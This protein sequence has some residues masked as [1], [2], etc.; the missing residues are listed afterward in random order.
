MKKIVDYLPLFSVCLIYF[1]F[2]NLHGYY[3]EF[4]I[5]IYLYITAS[6]II[7]AFF[8]T[9]VFIA[10]VM[11]TSLIQGFVG[12]P[13]YVKEVV[14]K[15]QSSPPSRLKIF[16]SSILESILTWIVIM[17]AVQ[18]IIKWIMTKYFGYEAFDFQIFNLIASIF[19]LLGILWYLAH[20]GQQ[21][22]IRKSPTIA[23]IVIVCYMGL[24]I[25][26]YRKLD[27]DRLKAG[28]H[29]REISFTYHGKSVST[30]KTLMY[31]GQTANH[32]FMYDRAK[33]KTSFYKTTELD[34]LI[35]SN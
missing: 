15:V 18:L 7:M 17:L 25:S 16:F 34:S 30:S 29:Q 1:G 20:T 9:I 32:L 28:I 14:E 19:F 33:K 2:C 21:D 35:V 22:L 3:K 8:P 5:D 6:E 31:I 26:N 4:N 11:G 23:A 10:G 13:I 24:Q 12:K 27:A